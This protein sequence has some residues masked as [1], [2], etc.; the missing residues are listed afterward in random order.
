M[1]E[2]EGGAEG[3]LRSIVS[4]GWADEDADL[5]HDLLE[6]ARHLASLVMVDQGASPETRSLAADLLDRL[7][8]DR[9]GRS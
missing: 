4:G 2:P 8:S 9:F 6:Q 5:V 7:R 1:A 3:I